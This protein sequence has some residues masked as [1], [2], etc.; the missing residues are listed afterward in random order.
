MRCFNCG[1]TIDNTAESCPYCGKEQG[2][3]R[4]LYEAAKDGDQQACAV[5]YNLCYGN[6]YYTVKSMVKDEDTIQDIVQDTFI[7]AFRNL[8]AIEYMECKFQAWIRSIAHNVTVNYVKK[9]RPILFSEM[10]TDD[11]EGGPDFADEREE[12]LPEAVVD[13]DETARLIQ[14]ILDSLSD[15]QRLAVGMYYYEQYSIREIAETMGVSQ[16]TIK[17]RLNYARKKIEE[18][19]RE[20]EKKGTRL[21]GLSPIPFLLFLFW[22]QGVQSTEIPN[23]K[24]LQLVQKAVAVV[25]EGGATAGKATAAATGRTTAAATVS[26]TGAVAAKGIGIKIAAGVAAVGIF[27]GGLAYTVANRNPE[28][29]IVIQPETESEIETETEPAVEVESTEPHAMI[30]DVPDWEAEE[31]TVL[32]NDS[33]LRS[34][35]TSIVL[36]STADEITGYAD[37][38]AWDVSEAGDGSV[39]AYAVQD[40]YGDYILYLVSEYGVYANTDSSYLFAYYTQAEKIEFNGLFFTDQATDMSGMFCECEALQEVDLS[41]FDT[42]NVRDMNNMFYGCVSLR[43]VDLSSFD[44]ANVTDMTYMFQSCSSL[45]SLDLSGFDTSAVEYMSYMFD[46]CSALADLDISS[47]QTQN[48]TDMSYMFEGC[49]E[50]SSLDVSSFQTQN[51]T[52]MSYMFEGC[53]SLQTLDL[54]SF[55]T[56]EVVL[57]SSMFEACA[58]LTSLDVS[59]FD[60]AGVENMENMFRGCASLTTL[61]LS[62]FDTANVGNMNGMFSGCSLLASLD[63]SSFDT[64]NVGDM[65]EMFYSCSSL[66]IDLSSFDMTNVSNVDSMT[67]GCLS[68]TGLE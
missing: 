33:L 64:S 11:D 12:N 36:Q 23:T 57:M 45:Y 50:L 61:D 39:M 3:S 22:K 34:E 5:I 27:G 30:A 37:D 6:V 10:E 62:S 21:Y 67:D 15:E 2:V 31:Q 63:I 7:K 52:D 19:V 14:E 59:S 55:D 24:T 18:K 38:M 9:R 47:L 49:Y 58:S 53:E 68:V 17:S 51:V 41:S 46:G 40:E 4:E 35:V 32:G 28:E 60:T 48:V 43:E 56:S 1:K 66:S 8:D 20:L 54:T 26:K 13:H 42:S 29:E 44:T 16:G 25:Q 65:S